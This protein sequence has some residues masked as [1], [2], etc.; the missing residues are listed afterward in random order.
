[1]TNTDYTYCSGIS[2]PLRENCKRFLPDPPDTPLLWILPD[3]SDKSDS[4][5]M[6][7]P[8]KNTSY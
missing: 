2:C 3:Y 4:C 5:R 7:E 1:M 8:L 6:H